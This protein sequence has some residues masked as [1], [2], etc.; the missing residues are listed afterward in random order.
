MPCFYYSPHANA[1]TKPENTPFTKADLGS[2]VLCMCP[3]QWQDQYNMNKKG[4]TPMGMLW[5]LTLLEAIERVCTSKKGNLESF[6]KFSKKDEKGKKHP[7]TNSMASISKKVCFEKNCNLCKKHGGVYTTH[8][9]CD[10]CRFEKDKK[11]KSNF[12][13]AA[14]KGGKKGNPVNHNFPQL[15]KKIKKLEEALKKSG[16]KGQKSSY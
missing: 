14:E 2:H 6:E 8:S 5:L 11:E 9:T 13:R 1:S 4:M 15:T 3:L 12:H 7:G 10:C 16:K